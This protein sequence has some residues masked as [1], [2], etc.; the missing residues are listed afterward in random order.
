MALSYLFENW[1]KLRGRIANKYLFLFLD[2]DGTLVPIAKTPDRAL[3]SWK[4]RNLLKRLS[5]EEHF[6]IAIISGRALRD[7]KNKLR[8]S[9]IIYTGNHGLEIEGPHLNFSTPVPTEYRAT[10]E[11]IKDELTKRISS[12]KGAFIEDKG[13]SLS[14][15]FRLVDEDKR[16]LIKTIFHEVVIVYKIKGII[17][18]KS[19]K[20]VLEVRP[21]V[22]W[23]KGKVVLWLLARQQFAL[24][25]KQILPIYIGD[26]LTDEDAFK[27]LKNRGLTI[28]VGVPKGSYAQY[29]LKS[30]KEVIDFLRRISKI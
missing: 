23:D 10:L 22:N 3:I 27:A 17:K 14:L 8:L 19:G 26:D 7:I 5:E 20:M 2:Y 15:H 4:T 18:T 24:H 16:A 28:F 6:K 1:E 21:I 9:R 30:P 11:H 12:V 25:Q 29:Y 13:L